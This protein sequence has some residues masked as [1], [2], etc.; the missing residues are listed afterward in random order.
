[1]GKSEDVSWKEPGV[2]TGRQDDVDEAAEYGF[3]NFVKHTHIQ[4]NATR[5]WNSQLGQLQLFLTCL[6]RSFIIR[7]GLRTGKR[8]VD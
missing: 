4:L 3:C 7:S 2:S 1:M 5:E 6:R 8:L